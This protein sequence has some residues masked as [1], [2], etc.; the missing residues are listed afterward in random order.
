MTKMI[1]V[2]GGGGGAVNLWSTFQNASGFT[3]KNHNIP[4][5]KYGREMEGHAAEKFKEVLSGKEHENLNVKQCGLLLDKTYPFIGASPDRI[6]KCD[7]HKNSCLEV[8]CLYPICHKSS[9]D[10]DVSL[11]Y[12]S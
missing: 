9:T 2:V 11:P 3:Y 4:A 12:L 10:S 7:C 1:K 5:L 8:K 6:V